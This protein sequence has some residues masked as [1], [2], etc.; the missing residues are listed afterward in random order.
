MFFG[1]VSCD[2]IDGERADRLAAQ[3]GLSEHEFNR[4]QLRTRSLINRHRASIE[5]VAKALLTCRTL[6]GDEIDELMTEAGCWYIVV[7]FPSGMQEHIPGFHSEAEIEEWLAGKGR[8][9]WLSAR[10]FAE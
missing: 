8:Q 1:A 10:G 9:M 4:P 5:R 3:H 2:G 6:A 7:T